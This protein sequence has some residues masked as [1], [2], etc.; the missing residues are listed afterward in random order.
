MA[1]PSWIKLGKSSGSMNDSTT[2]TASEYTGRQQRGGTI[3]AKTTGGATDTTSVSQAGK[4]EFI[5]VPTKTYNA[6]A[7]GSNSD[8]SDT[9]QITGTANTA[10]IKVAETTGKIIPG[11]AYKIQVNAVNDDSWDGKTDT[12]I[13]DDPGKDAQFTFTIDVKIP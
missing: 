2:V 12:G 6:A 9:I 5:N 7:K 4:A 8:G 1:K 3:T 10:N 13:D 11:A